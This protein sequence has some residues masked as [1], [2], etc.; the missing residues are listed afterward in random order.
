MGDTQSIIMDSDCEEP[1]S[2]KHRYERSSTPIGEKP[3]FHEPPDI[4]SLN[5][6]EAEDF[7]YIGRGDKRNGNRDYPPLGLAAEPD[8]EQG[9]LYPDEEG[10]DY[11]G[12]SNEAM[13]K[14]LVLLRD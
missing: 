10:P 2:K 8:M 9:E 13:G 1:P 5:G 4:P 11:F 12:L 14:W 6:E 7:L 3:E